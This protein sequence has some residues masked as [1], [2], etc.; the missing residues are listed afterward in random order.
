MPAKSPQAVPGVIDI[1]S[2]TAILITRKFGLKPLGKDDRIAPAIFAQFEKAV[3][4]LIRAGMKLDDNQFQEMGL[5]SVKRFYDSVRKPPQVKGILATLSLRERVRRCASHPAYFAIQEVKTRGKI[6]A[7]LAQLLGA[8]H[9]SGDFQELYTTHF[10]GQKLVQEARS[11]LQGAGLKAVNGSTSRPFSGERLANLLRHLRNIEVAMV[12]ALYSE[13]LT[14]LLTIHLKSEELQ[15]QVI[16]WLQLGLRAQLKTFLS[17]LSRVVTERRKQLRKNQGAPFGKH[18]VDSI[19]TTILG[20]KSSS[21]AAWATVRKT[22]REN[23]F[24]NLSAQLDSINVEEL[25]GQ[26]TQHI[27]E[28]IQQNPL[29]LLNRIFKPSRTLTPLVSGDSFAHFKAYLREA[30]VKEVENVSIAKMKPEFMQRAQNTLEEFQRNP[31]KWLKRPHFQKQTIPFGI[32]DGQAYTLQLDRESD[33]QRLN[34]VFVTISVVSEEQLKF[35]IS[36]VARFQELLDQHFEPLRGTVSKKRGASGLILAVPFRYEPSSEPR[37][38]KPAVLKK[39]LVAALDL[40][41]KKFGVLSINECMIN[42]T[43]TWDKANPARADL[44]R[45]F[46]DQKQLAGSKSG[47]YL[48]NPTADHKYFNVKRRLTNL[49]FGARK[50]QAKMDRYRNQVSGYKSKTKFF[51]IRREYKRVWQKL[52]RIHEELTKQIAT[53]IIAVCLYHKVAVIRLEDLSWAKHAAKTSVGYFL[54]TWQVHWFY[55]QVQERLYEL[56]Q[57]ASIL[58]EWTDARYTSHRCSRCGEMGLRSGKKFQCSYCSLELDSDLNAA[59]VIAV[60][61]QSSAATRGRGGCPLPPNG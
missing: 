24:L 14:Q 38:V 29:H 50:L 51:V 28:V 12:K 33:T 37:T 57:R 30:A 27:L 49:Q 53:R 39:E 34:R 9:R 58:V 41:L 15:A 44:A 61:P 52:K 1:N 11:A 2:D 22:W 54:S 60:S 31:W 48:S 47:W 40:G 5:P 19:L 4:T 17:K 10:P 45:Y 23:R 16:P 35:R 55:S 6:L 25:A 32:D 36:D 46:I 8:R 43:G 26:A 18:K 56:A 21:S 7:V 20:D 3:N 42:A 59:R 13:R